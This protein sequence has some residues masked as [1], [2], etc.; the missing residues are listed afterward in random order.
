MKK[1]AYVPIL[2]LI[3]ILVIEVNAQG[4]FV[5]SVNSNKY[6][7]PSCDSVEQI[8]EENR[9]WFTSPED[10]TSQGYIPCKSCN[11]PFVDKISV[12]VDYVIDGDTFDTSKGARIRLADI[13]APNSTETGY[14]ESKNYLASLVENKW[15]II[16]VDNVTMTDT[17][18]NRL[19]CLVYLQHNSTHHLNVN[20]ALLNEGHAIIW[21]WT[22]NEFEPLTWELYYSTEA[23]PEGLT[24]AVMA[25]LTTVSMLVGYKYFIKRK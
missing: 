12:Y 18:D 9:I 21:D 15:V 24:F 13:N 14:I 8:A 17:Y 3:L 25:L 22:N 5:G 6:H 23:I 4:Q 16:D 19:V 2:F 10:A 7:Y 11:P 1:I 20:Q